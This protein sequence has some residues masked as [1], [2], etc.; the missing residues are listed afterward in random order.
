MVAALECLDW[1][2]PTGLDD[3]VD[4]LRTNAQSA[5]RRGVHTPWESILA[6]AWLQVDAVLPD[7]AVVAEVLWRMV[8][9]AVIDPRSAQAVRELR[10]SGRRLVLACN[11]QRPIA[12]RR[13]T[14]AAAELADCFDALVLSSEIGTC[15]PQLSVDI[16][17]VAV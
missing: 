7:M 4:S 8:P 5:Y 17:G 16:V 12:H 15:V 13:R 14:L 11:T 3:A 2:C 1:P 10:R 9:D 6:A